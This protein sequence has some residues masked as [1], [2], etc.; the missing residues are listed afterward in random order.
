M[1]IDL[2]LGRTSKDCQIK[3]DDIDISP[4]T[5][6][7]KVEAVVGQITTVTLELIPDAVTVDGIDIE[8]LFVEKDKE[9]EPARLD[10][11]QPK[12]IEEED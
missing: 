2:T 5:R 8:V 11:A 3:L 4:R 10:A 9:T 6:G 7:V 1:K 12:G